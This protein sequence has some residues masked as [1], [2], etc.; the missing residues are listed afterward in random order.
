MKVVQKEKVI[1]NNV[2]DQFCNEIKI[3]CYL[4][5]PHLVTLYGIFSDSDN[6]YLLMELLCDNTLYREM[7]SQRKHE[8]DTVS[9]WLK[10][11]CSGVEYMHREKVMHRDIKP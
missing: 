8:E 10:Q 3:Q 7:R 11:I 4:R 2:M 5:H 1:K 9:L 6:I